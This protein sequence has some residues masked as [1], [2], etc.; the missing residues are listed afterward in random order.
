MRVSLASQSRV[1][2][3]RFVREAEGIRRRRR[4]GGHR[5]QGAYSS[6]CVLCCFP[7]P[8]RPGQLQTLTG[9]G[10]AP[11]LKAESL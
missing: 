10:K 3:R 1:G 9:K 2:D 4:S 6:E 8:G 7:D 11:F 5:V